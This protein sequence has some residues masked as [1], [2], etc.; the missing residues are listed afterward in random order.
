MFVST[1]ALGRR[2]PRLL[3]SDLLNCHVHVSFDLL[4]ASPWKLRSGASNCGPPKLRSSLLEQHRF[5]QFATL[6]LGHPVDLPQ[7]LFNLV[8]CL[9]HDF[10]FLRW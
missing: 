4:L 3:K 1:T 6:L 2:R 10:L 8:S 7:Y 9:S 5:E